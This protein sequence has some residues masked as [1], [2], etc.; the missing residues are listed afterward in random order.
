M[1]FV[2]RGIKKATLR[3]NRANAQSLLSVLRP[4]DMLYDD[5]LPGSVPGRGMGAVYIR[6]ARCNVLRAIGVALHFQNLWEPSRIGRHAA[7][8]VAKQNSGCRREAEAATE[9]RRSKRKDLIMLARSRQHGVF[10][11]CSEHVRCFLTL[12]PL[13]ARRAGRNQA[14]QHTYGR[15]PNRKAEKERPPH[16]SSLGL[17]CCGRLCGAT[18]PDLRRLSNALEHGSSHDGNRRWCRQAQVGKGKAPNLKEAATLCCVVLATLTPEQCKEAA[19]THGC[20][21]TSMSYHGA[22]KHEKLTNRGTRPTRFYNAFL[23]ERGGTRNGKLPSETLCV[24][25]GRVA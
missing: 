25:F 2:S 19:M 10:S 21:R 20:K 12:F 4:P 18:H 24:L 23:Y 1:A 9:S 13:L 5:P 11:S 7:Q 8:G 22:Q 15:T 6:G 16:V 14:P 17:C 3:P